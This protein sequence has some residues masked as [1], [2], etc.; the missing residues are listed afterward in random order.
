MRLLAC[1]VLSFVCASAFAA[2][3]TDLLLEKASSGL[4]RTFALE[5]T[6]Q[7][8]AEFAFMDVPLESSGKL[9]FSLTEG[10]KFIFWEYRSPERSGFRWRDGTVELW[11]GQTSRPASASERQ[12]LNGMTEQLL[13]W[14]AFDPQQLKKR[15]HIEPGATPL[16]LRFIPREKSELFAAIELTFSPDLARI[17]ELKFSGQEQEVTTLRFNV[18]SQNSA[19]SEDCRR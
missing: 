9:C 12:F 6:F 8:R 19:L 11:T 5:A 18:Q 13:Q 10:Q 2:E 4:A 1:L 17:A 14:T 7:Q 16:S 15:Y 3:N